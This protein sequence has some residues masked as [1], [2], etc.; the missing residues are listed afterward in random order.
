MNTENGSKN[1]VLYSHGFGVREDDRGLFTDIASSLSSFSHVM[2]DYNQFDEDTNTLI[3]APL[4]AQAEMLKSQYIRLRD[5]NPSAVIDLIC[6]S[7]GCVVSGLTALEG[8]RNVIMLAPPT[9]FRSSEHEIQ[10]MLQREGAVMEDGVVRYPRRD[11][12]ITIIKQDY[13]ASRD[14]VPSLIELYNNLSTRSQ[15]LIVDALNDE[16]LTETDYSGL[17]GDIAL[18]HEEASH[19]F[20]DESRQALIAKITSTLTRD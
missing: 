14:K 8:V 19:D 12:S 5:N 20:T 4:D 18:I 2:F 7:Q 3:V 15:V 16:V 1:I 9:Q 13:W 11:G 17:I 10:Q 6:H